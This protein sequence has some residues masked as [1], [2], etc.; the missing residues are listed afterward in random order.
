MGILYQEP[1][2]AAP[3][4]CEDADGVPRHNVDDFCVGV[5]ATAVAPTEGQRR[6][7]TA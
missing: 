6:Q 3:P 4:M 2:P 1:K 7:N 5:G